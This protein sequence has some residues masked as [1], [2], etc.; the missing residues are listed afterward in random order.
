MFGWIPASEYEKLIETS[1]LLFS[2]DCVSVCVCA[3]ACMHVRVLCVPI[4][5]YVF[6]LFRFAD[7][8]IGLTLAR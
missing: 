5:N 7:N 1:E 3:R 4:I 2:T 8:G 6:F